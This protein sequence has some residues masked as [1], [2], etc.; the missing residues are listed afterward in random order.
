M[1][2][3]DMTAPSKNLDMASISENLLKQALSWAASL[4]DISNEGISILIKHPSSNIGTDRAPFLGVRRDAQRG[5]Q[6][7]TGCRTN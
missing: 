6:A 4:A 7:S 2:L 5:A 3:N 1:Q